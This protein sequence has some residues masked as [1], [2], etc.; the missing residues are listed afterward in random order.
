MV[1]WSRTTK[2]SGET[3]VKFS[4]A[5]F[6]MEPSHYLPVA[7]AAEEA[8]FDAIAV[9]DSVFYPERVSADYPYTPDGSRFWTADAP[10]VDPWVAIPA[11]A[12][13]TRRLRFYTN[14]LKLPIRS[15]LL[16]AKT[17]GSAAVLSDNRVALGVGL[18]WMPEEFAWCGTDWATRG[19]RID[20][21]IEIVRRVLSGGMVEYHGKHYDF[22]RLQMSPAP[23][24]PVPI[25]VGGH[26]NPGL[27]RAARLGDGWVS[28]NVTTAEIQRAIEQLRERRAEFGRSDLPFE[29]KVVPTDA[30]DVES[31][32]RLFELGV[33][34]LIVIPWL[35]YGGDPSSLDAKRRGIERFANEVI[36]KLRS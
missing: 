28:V 17:V 5:T 29:I 7:V 34:D 19:P 18:S 32:R 25:Y 36:A 6:M 8:G 15:P 33:T 27:R 24:E 9:P 30:F 12:A 20:E 11:M 26:S 14:V 21:A 2:A 35:L 31:Y 4:I 1:A 3:G 16:V 22:D 23:T 13:V 10:W